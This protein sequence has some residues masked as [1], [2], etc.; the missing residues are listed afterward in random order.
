MTK[1]L[2]AGAVLVSLASGAA[3]ANPSPGA[4][5]SP[6]APDVKTSTAAPVSPTTIYTGDKMRDPFLKESGAVVTTRAYNM[7]EFNIHNLTL[8]ALMRDKKADYA[9]FT[10]N[11]YGSSFILRQ[12]KLR[13]PRGKPVP[14]VSGKLDIKH[15][16]ANLMT[17]ESDVQVFRLG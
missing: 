1:A 2:L 3:A 13:D 16:M 10:D 12:G 14:G 6:K 9:L 11:T 15:K 17:A 8:R 4:V 5:P 7:D